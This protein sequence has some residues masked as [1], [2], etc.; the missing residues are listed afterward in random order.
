LTLQGANDADV[1]SFD[2][3]RQWER[4]RF[5]ADGPWFKAELYIYRAN[6]GQFNSV[7][8]RWDASPPMAWLLNVKPLLSG[9]EQRKIARVY[10]SAFLEATLRGRREYIPI[11]QDYRRGA[12]WLP[13]SVYL[14]R[15]QDASFHPVCTY[16]ED[17]DVAST[18]TPGGLIHGENLAVLKEQRIAFRNGSREDNAVYLG[19]RKPE[20]K[21]TPPASYSIDLPEAFARDRKLGAASVLEFSLSDAGEEPPPPKDK[22]KSKP[23]PK[24]EAKKDTKKEPLDLSVE[25]ASRSGPAVRLPL[26]RFGPLYAPLK[27]RFIKV[28]PPFSDPYGKEAEPVLHR[29]ALPLAA[30]AEAGKGFDPASL[31]VIRFVFDRSA[32]G[33]VVVDNIGFSAAR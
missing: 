27:A 13:D 6:H 3:S 10:I 9:E 8:G 12:R 17:F 18:T 30:F 22:D 33:V 14:N 20:K 7:W 21:D 1:S 26:S 2:G 23:E 5:T 19:W 15:Y 25:L 4:V 31:K 29:Y 16:E 11:F 28:K 24:K 32:E